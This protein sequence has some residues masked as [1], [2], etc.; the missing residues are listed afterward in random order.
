VDV[1]GAVEPSDLFS[2]NL[3]QTQ[4]GLNF[5][6]LIQSNNKTHE[7]LRRERHLCVIGDPGMCSCD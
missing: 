3:L 6:Q 4:L 7:F 5:L 1:S 2:G